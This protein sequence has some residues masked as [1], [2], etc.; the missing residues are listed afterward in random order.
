MFRR[1]PGKPDADDASAYSRRS[2]VADSVWAAQDRVR[3]GLAGALERAGFELQKH[4]V[5][6]LQDRAATVGSPVRALSF[7]GVALLAAGALAAGLIVAEPDGPGGRAATQVAATTAPAKPETPAPGPAEPTLQGAAPVFEPTE[8]QR[9][10]ELDPAKAIVKSAPAEAAADSPASAAT[11][12]AATSSSAEPGPEV[13]GPPAGPAAIA[14]AR[15]FADAFVLYETGETGSEVRR[16]FGES[17][18]PAL[19]RALLE[20]PPRL[21][22]NVD[23]PKAKVVNLVPAPSRGD[24]YPVSVSLLRV[25]LTSE[26]RLD[27]EQRKGEGWRVANVLG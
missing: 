27:L 14:V 6:P 20:R 1:R 3:T 11:S 24:I 21:P 25:G 22:A 4:L 15:D 9:P 7:G 5:W 10:S 19:A 23:V 18:T 16:A 12:S 13:D 26:L 2:A 8:G 17:A